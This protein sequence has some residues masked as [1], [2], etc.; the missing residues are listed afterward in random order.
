MAV[1]WLTR[2]ELQAWLEK[3]GAKFSEWTIDKKFANRYNL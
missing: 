2:K 3:Q 1:E